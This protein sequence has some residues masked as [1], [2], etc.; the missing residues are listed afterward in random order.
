M[1]DSTEQQTEEEG[2]GRGGRAQ[3]SCKTSITLEQKKASRQSLP[4]SSHRGDDAPPPDREQ[5][6]GSQQASQSVSVGEE[7]HGNHTEH[8]PS[9]RGEVLP[10]QETVA[11]H[12]PATQELVVGGAR[13]RVPLGAES[14]VCVTLTC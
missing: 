1:G 5:P 9:Y 8:P 6:L 2:K 7:Y 14:S 4:L 10:Q 11:V 3:S 12:S 13:R